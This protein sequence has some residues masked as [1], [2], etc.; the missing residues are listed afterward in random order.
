[1]VATRGSKKRA[2]PKNNSDKARKKQKNKS[3]TF[4]EFW[5]N[6]TRIGK[7]RNEVNQRVDAARNAGRDKLGGNSPSEILRDELFENWVNTD[8]KKV[9]F[10]RTKNGKLTRHQGE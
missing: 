4:L 10:K 9:N 1:M 3:E 8:D 6:Q 7:I 5:T 2:A